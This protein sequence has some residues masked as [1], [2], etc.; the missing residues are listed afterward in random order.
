MNVEQKKLIIV[1]GIT[2]QDKIAP[3][4]AEPV[5]IICTHGTVGFEKM[6]T[7][8]EQLDGRDVYILVDADDA[9]NALRRQLQQELPNA[10][11][12]YIK[13]MHKEVARTPTEELKRI[14]ENAHFDVQSDDLFPFY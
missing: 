12:L 2:D 5:D 3:L 13:K 14:L 10:A 6:E 4:I 7:L 9:G 1:E 8:I 11:H